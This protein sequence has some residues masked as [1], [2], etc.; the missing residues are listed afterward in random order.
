MLNN[1]KTKKAVNGFLLLWSIYIQCILPRLVLIEGRSRKV[2]G[3]SESELE[4]ESDSKAGSIQPRIKAVR[5]EWRPDWNWAAC[6]EHN[7]RVAI[8]K[9][10]ACGVGWQTWAHLGALGIIWDRTVVVSE[11]TTG[12]YLSYLTPLRGFKNLTLLGQSWMLMSE[13]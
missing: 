6:G 3:D 13:H 10:G 7:V 2:K 8:E 5:W 9:E 12:T 1:K 4:D 11:A